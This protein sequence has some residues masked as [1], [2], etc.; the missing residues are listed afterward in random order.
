MQQA[1]YEACAGAHIYV[2]AAAVGDYRPD[3]VAPCKLKKQ[4]GAELVLRLAENPDIIGSLAAQ[5]GHPF[6]V[7]FAAETNEVATYARDKLVRK[8]LD[9]ICANRVGIGATGF[10][11]D[12]N[13]LLVLG[14]DGF[15]HALGPAS[16]TELAELLLDLIE[17]HLS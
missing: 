4:A 1:V 8:R 16:K 10:E 14:R 15:E 12:D 5:A 3:E 9:L 11:S 13:A 2:G 7:G 17:Q 6:L